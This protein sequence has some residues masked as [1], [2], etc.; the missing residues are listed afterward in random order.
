MFPSAEITRLDERIEELTHQK[1][2]RFADIQKLE[3]IITP[4]E[5]T[6]WTGAEEGADSRSSAL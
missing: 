2:D 6:A 1:R 5:K 3:G 4:L